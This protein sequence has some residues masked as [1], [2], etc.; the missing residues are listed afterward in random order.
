MSSVQL[1]RC[2]MKIE[3]WNERDLIIANSAW[4]FF[5]ETGPGPNEWC[6][7]FTSYC[8]HTYESVREAVDDEDTSY[9]DFFQCTK[10]KEKMSVRITFGC[11]VCKGRHLQFVGC[12]YNFYCPQNPVVPFR[13]KD[14]RGAQFE[15]LFG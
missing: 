15:V 10:C 6:F 13:M 7:T 1:R 11:P 14:I 5:G 4:D 12:V 2:V 3:E 8:K 9:R